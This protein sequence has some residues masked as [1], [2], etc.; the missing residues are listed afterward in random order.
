MLPTSGY[1]TSVHRGKIAPSKRRKIFIE[2]HGSI[3]SSTPYTFRVK[4]LI[5]ESRFKY[6]HLLLLVVLLTLPE[7]VGKI[8]W[9]PEV[10]CCE[11]NGRIKSYKR[12]HWS[13]CKTRG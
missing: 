9:I 4:E 6:C 10:A 1:S 2:R 7:V 13:S 11:Q 5:R 12:K 8:L 3:D